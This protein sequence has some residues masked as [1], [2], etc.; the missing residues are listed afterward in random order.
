MRVNLIGKSNG[1]GLSRDLALLADALRACGCDVAVLAVD[2]RTSHR[3]RLMWVQGASLLRYWWRKHV[4]RNMPWEADVNVMME[5]LWPESLPMARL[6]VAVPNPEWFDRHDLRMLP[7]ID[8]VWAKTHNTQQIFQAMRCLVSYVGFNSE[9]R[10]DPSV[11]RR[12]GFFHLA[13]QSTMKGTRRLLELWRGH[14]QW[15]TLT[16]VQHAQ[17]DDDPVA[18]NIDYRTGYMDDAELQRLQNQNL[19]HLCTSETEGWGHYLVEAMSVGA[20][21]VT[22]DAPPMN[23]LVTNERG[24][25]LRAEVYRK[26]K[27]ADCY[28]FEPHSLVT[29]V[30]RMSAMSDAE[31]G[32]LCAAARQWFIDNK[33]EFYGRVGETMEGL[34]TTVHSSPVNTRVVKTSLIITT[35]NWNEALELVFRSI[36]RQSEMPDEVL[37]ADDGSG[38]D[39]ADLVRQWSAR[40]PI[41]VRHVWQEDRG[42]RLAR[43]RNQAIAAA[44]GD[45]IIIVDGDTVLHRHF[46]ADHKRAARYGYFIQGVR[47]LTGPQMGQRMLAEGLLDIGFFAPHIRRRRHTVR[48]RF[49][50]WLLYRQVHEHQNAI[51]GS[52]QAYWRNDL[53]KVN[54]FDERMTGWGR[55]DNEIAQRLYNVGIRRRNLKFAALT[56]HIYHH[57][58]KTTGDN[59][60]DRYLHET[61]ENKLTWCNLGI[62]QH[63]LAATKIGCSTEKY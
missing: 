49:L 13:G 30:E 6:N 11:Q 47:L 63:L 10:L 9:D 54:G 44:S 61:I 57:Q 52:N 1:V 18:T 3:R 48:N 12:R 17:A 36:A 26:Q 38:P 21:T 24:L 27:L 33:T 35:Y 56:I 7:C 14:P 43:S 19:F 31:A 28:R 62:D 39:T 23:E 34:K 53:L 16:V 2:S 46:V 50:S 37:I 59:P 45:Y 51:R 25:L 60:N 58:R 4:R 29:A 42:F 40:L 15:P 5:H 8:R 20:V 22:L 32:Q 41:P 55:E